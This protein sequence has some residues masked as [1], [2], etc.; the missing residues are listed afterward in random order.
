MSET[1]VVVREIPEAE[2][3]EF[4]DGRPVLRGRSLQSW[5]EEFDGYVGEVEQPT[6][7]A[8]FKV[9]L[10]AWRDRDPSSTWLDVMFETERP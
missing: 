10:E 2:R 9:S 7:G 3:R 5:M 1:R 4:V 6:T 8:K